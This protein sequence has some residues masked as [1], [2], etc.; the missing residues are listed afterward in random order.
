MSEFNPQIQDTGIPDSSNVSQG[1]GVN[2]T[3]ETLFS[4]LTQTAEN[5]LQIRDTKTKMDIEDDAQSMFGDV[6][7][8]FGVS[9]PEGVTDGLDQIQV[10]QNALEQGKISEVNYYGRLATLSKQMR[11]RYPGYESV[12]DSTIQSVT[13]TRPANAYRDAIFSQISQAQESASSEDKFQRQY[14]KENEGI[15]AA[16]M[17]D[18]LTNP[19]KYSFQQVQATV[20]QYKGQEEKINSQTKQLQLMS[21]T[22]QFN[23]TLATKS[24][25]QDF[26]FITQSVLTRAVN[27]NDPSYQER[28]NTF[29]AKGGGTPEET[30]Q[31][32]GTISEAE[33]LLRQQLLTRGRTEYVAH[34]ILTNEQLNK[35]VDDAMY[36]L[37]E[38]KKAV[39]GGDF[40]LAS[41]YATINKIVQDKAVAD[42]FENNPDIRVGSG[43]TTISQ[44][45]G[46][47]WFTEKRD[48]IFG[49]INDAQTQTL[50]DEV[51]GQVM[52]GD[53]TKIDQAV[54][55]GDAKLTRAT[56]NS[57]FNALT[58][59][60]IDEKQVS[61]IVKSLFGPQ[62]TDWMD[63]RIVDPSDMESLYT[64][65]LNPKVTQAIF[66][67]GSKEDQ[68][69][70]FMWAFTKARAIPAFAAAAGDVNT[71]IAAGQTS[72]NFDPKTMR[73]SLSVNYADMGDAY[74]QQAEKSLN[75]GRTV[76][77]L[78]KVF[79]AMAPIIEARG[80]NKEEVALEFVKSL[81]IG[82][83]GVNPTA[84]GPEAKKDSSFY[85]W[86][87]SQMS[88]SAEASEGPKQSASQIAEVA[89]D[90]TELDFF[91]ETAEQPDSFTDEAVVPTDGKWL[92]YANQGATRSK[93]LSKKLV[94]SLG[95]FLPGMG[96]Q[97]KVFSGGQDSSGPNRTGSHRHDHGNAADVFFYQNG[98]KLDWNKES[99]RPV[100]EEIVRRAKKAGVQ[101]IGAGE[102]YMQPGSMH[103]GLGTPA[104]WGRGGKGRNAPDWL[105]QAFAG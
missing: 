41:K 91:S 88:M 14:L 18:Y 79:S 45:L 46:A 60:N 82:L 95:S 51:A 68:D 48:S 34:G 20:A 58:N 65:F 104:V 29:V 31:F 7:N 83:D 74:R 93:P 61:N 94:N 32:I 37:K 97:M 55:K 26:T 49:Q 69:A 42:L 5:V 105:Q 85:S 28:I 86:L 71:L 50:A 30:N 43:L 22:N 10:L 25:S 75:A 13:G 73:V 92:Q 103:I 101:G 15:V 1:P 89:Q 72:L 6:N 8:E 81:S 59:A 17:P 2:R 38:A 19:D 96:I 66:T 98:R 102:G 47:E 84:Q 78:N 57:S 3:F 9:A 35:A 53:P 76:N 39:L 33:T 27:A 70:Y 16:T 12:V 44:S 90:D 24:V 4:G 63:R 62:A 100:F 36:P 87:Y 23:E 77:V 64:K 80:G 21:S 67:K 54:K 56:L 52:Q 40:T 99:D 11:S